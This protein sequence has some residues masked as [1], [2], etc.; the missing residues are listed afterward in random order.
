MIAIYRNSCVTQPVDNWIMLSI[1]KRFC[2]YIRSFRGEVKLDFF[3]SL[4]YLF[5][6]GL[7]PR[8]S[9]GC[10]SNKRVCRT[11][12]PM[13][14]ICVWGNG[15]SFGFNYK[16]PFL[17][18]IQPLTLSSLSFLPLVTDQ[19]KKEKRKEEEKRRKRKGR[20]FSPTMMHAW[21]APSYWSQHHLH[22][23]YDLARQVL[24]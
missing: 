6:M 11:Q 8:S 20:W 3:S 17:S 7:Y 14:Y 1:A 24:L 10:G 2:L 12:L 15:L 4:G 9:T 21:M 5:L 22:H 23:L 18:C 19:H 16:T 13:L